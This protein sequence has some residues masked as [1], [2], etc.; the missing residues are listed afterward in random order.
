VTTNIHLD[1]LV[2][3][4]IVFNIHYNGYKKLTWPT[5][6]VPRLVMFLSLSIFVSWLEISAQNN[7]MNPS[8]DTQTK[9][10]FMIIFYFS[11]STW[12]P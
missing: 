11:Q 6:I 1:Q 10:M 4:N 3:I 8:L 12:A 7:A 5:Y 9:E 2:P